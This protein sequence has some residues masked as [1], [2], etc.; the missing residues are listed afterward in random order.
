M[1][2]ELNQDPDSHRYTSNDD[3]TVVNNVADEL[4]LIAVLKRPIRLLPHAAVVRTNLKY[5]EQEAAPSEKIRCVK[6]MDDAHAPEITSGQLIVMKTNPD[7]GFRLLDLFWAQQNKRLTSK[8][9][10]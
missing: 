4:Q 10:R 3:C 2:R 8:V 9:K 7:A 5:L 1:D 6:M